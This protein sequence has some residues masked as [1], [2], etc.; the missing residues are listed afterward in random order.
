MAVAN[1]T[2]LGCDKCQQW[3][4][5]GDLGMTESQFKKLT[6]QDVW[7][8]PGCVQ[9]SRERLE[10]AVHTKR[11]DLRAVWMDYSLIIMLM[12]MHPHSHVLYAREGVR[13]W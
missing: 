3:F 4:G 13:E 10:E 12:Y 7:I 8:C 1:E 11:T 5:P 2:W 6:Q 9:L